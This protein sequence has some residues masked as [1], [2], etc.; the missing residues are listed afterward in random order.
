MKYLA[1]NQESAIKS[2][3]LDA[4][5]LIPQLKPNK[6]LNVQLKSIKNQKKT[7]FY[8]KADKSNTI[9]II[10]KDEYYKRAQDM[11][12]EGPYVKMH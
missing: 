5:S 9:V 12:N 6:P 3:I 4:L 2:D 11:L 7:V 8:L 10:D 1:Q